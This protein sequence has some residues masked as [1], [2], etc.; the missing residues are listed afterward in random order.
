[1]NLVGGA[2]RLDR[3]A[4][5]IIPIVIT[6][7]MVV[8]S[9]TPI[10]VPYSVAIAPSLPLMAVY[11]WVVLR[12]ELMPRTAVFAIGLVHDALIGAPLGVNAL[13]LLLAHA[14][15]SSQRR[16]LVGKSFWLFWLGFVIL[17]PA[18]GALTWVLM[19]ILRGA[20][21]APD[22]TLFN[23]LMTI[24]V[25]PLLAWILFHTQRALVGQGD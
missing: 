3:W 18:A 23:L 11:Y 25:F 19:S 14:I 13:V 9:V 10:P 8:I 17:A 22:A 4:R 5:N 24:A 15:L 1:M 16:Y 21:V 7:F 12:P 2:A 6:L 20:L